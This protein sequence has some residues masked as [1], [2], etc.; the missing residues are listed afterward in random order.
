MTVREMQEGMAGVETPR[1]APISY[2]GIAADS[3]PAAGR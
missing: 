1:S 3:P 2:P